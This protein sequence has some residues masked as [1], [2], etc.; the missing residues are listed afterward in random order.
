MEIVSSLHVLNVHI[1]YVHYT[2]LKNFARLI[3]SLVF[4]LRAFVADQDVFQVLCLS[5]CSV[6]VCAIMVYFGKT[7]LK[8]KKTKQASLKKSS[9]LMDV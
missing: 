9:Y 8:E 6:S 1:Q 5:N 7:S 2:Y 4:M 3:A